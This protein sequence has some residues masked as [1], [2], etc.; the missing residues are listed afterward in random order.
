MGLWTWGHEKIWKRNV[1]DNTI[2]L[3]NSILA[4]HNWRKECNGGEIGYGFDQYKPDTRFHYSE[5]YALWGRGYL[6]LFQ[7]T[8]QKM[9]LNLAEKCADWLIENKNL[10]YE[11]Y[12]WG[13]PWDWDGRANEFSYITTTTFVGDFFIHFYEITKDKKYLS[14]AK[15]IGNWIVEE[16]GFK[17]NT[18]GIWFF[19]SDHHSLHYPVINAIAMASGFFSKLYSHVQNS[20]YKELAVESTKYIINNQNRDGSWYYSTESSYIDNVHTGFTIDGL[21]DVCMTFPPITET[22]QKRLIAA[23]DFYWNKLYSP[24]GFGKESVKNKLL[25]KIKDKLVPNHETRLHGYAAG[26]RA[27]TKLSTILDIENKGL[28]IAKYAMKTLQAENGAFKFTS[29][30]DKYYI[31]NEAHIFDALTTIISID[32]PIQTL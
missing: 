8:Q 2:Y 26:I 9:F 32:M 30:E 24:R 15:S 6:K 29:D 25:H 23:H 13:L 21:C 11:N 12:S 20:D 22:L 28:E 7:N 1:E 16:N 5:A 31:R 10:K 17:E 27:F 4:L 3:F 14:V 18:D 19:Y